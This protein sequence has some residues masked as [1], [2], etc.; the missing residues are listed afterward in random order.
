MPKFYWVSNAARSSG[1]WVAT[2]S[3]ARRLAHRLYAD[4]ATKAPGT[5]NCYR[6]RTGTRIS[7][8]VV[9]ALLRGGGALL[10]Y[11]GAVDAKPN[12]WRK[13]RDG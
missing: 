6:L 3:A 7:R 9:V 4:A 12:W 2:I 8:I 5:I 11:V 10:E 13:S 1:E